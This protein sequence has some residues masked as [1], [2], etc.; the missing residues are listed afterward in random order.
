MDSQE[1]TLM[2]KKQIITMALMAVLLIAMAAGYMVFKG[3]QE[4]KLARE[5][6][7]EEKED[8]IP[9]FEMNSDDINEISYTYNG[10]TT[11]MVSKDDI[12]IM[13]GTDRPMNSGYIDDIKS[14][15]SSV[16][17]IKVITEDTSNPAEYGLDDESVTLSYRVSC[18][19]GTAHTL[20][21][22]IKVTTED[23]A[24]YAMVDDDKK[25]YSMSANYYDILEYSLAEMTEIVDEVGIN[26]DYITEVDVKSK[27]NGEFSARYFGD[28]ADNGYYTWEITRP[29]KNVLA[30]TDKWK[31]MLTKYGSMEL[32]KC[33]AFGTDDYSEYGLD[34]PEATIRLKY[35]TVTGVEEEDSG[36]TDDASSEDSSAS[37]TP[38]PEEQREYDEL[39]LYISEPK[40]EGDETF[41]YV[42]PEGSSNVYTMDSDAQGLYAFTPFE[43]ADVCI[44]SKLIDQIKGYD[45]EFGDK[46]L[47][48]ERRD[49]EPEAT[50][51]PGSVPKK[52]DTINVYY[53]NG[54]KVE[55]DDALNLYSFAYLLTYSGEADKNK[56]DDSDIPALTITYHPV[57]GEDVVVK[58]MPYDGANFYHVDKNGMNYFLTDKR[59]IDTLI[60]NYEEF[61]EKNSL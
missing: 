59:G 35:Y 61:I 31:A 19:D 36:D 46:K 8:T 53:A 45:V 24:Y 20:K 47:V 3:Y 56:A 16:V 42:R 6:E 12:W 18:S 21:F 44:Y 22:G 7:Q 28:N 26:S 33:V 40:T 14:A 48:I 60:K 2:K 15:M 5:E 41:F 52:K 13:K 57:E 50:A 30:D 23:S 38:V 32:K 58:Y 54:K 11:D 39:T 55:E 9:L 43:V 4:D 37:A 25:I 10:E 34:D 49:E 29:Y 51:E 17:A 1:E 27:D